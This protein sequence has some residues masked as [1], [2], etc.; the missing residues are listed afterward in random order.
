MCTCFG[1]RVDN[2]H[3]LTQMVHGHAGVDNL[4]DAE[5][6]ADDVCHYAATDK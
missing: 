3:N 6:A 4:L 2:K 1:T 5:N